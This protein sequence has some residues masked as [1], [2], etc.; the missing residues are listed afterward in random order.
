MIL[1]ST[2]ERQE[3]DNLVEKLANKLDCQKIEISKYQKIK[4]QSPKIIARQKQH[5][6][7]SQDQLLVY[8]NEVEYLQS[9]LLEKTQPQC[10]LQKQ[11]LCGQCVLYV[12]P[13]RKVSFLKKHHTQSTII[14]SDL[15]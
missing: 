10:P 5:I 15:A 4:Q 14:F 3:L 7:R 13:E 6:M 8:Q 9:A 1:Q 2:K 12:V 11:E